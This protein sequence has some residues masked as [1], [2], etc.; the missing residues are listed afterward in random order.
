[1]LRA[2]CLDDYRVRETGRII[3]FAKVVYEIDK[4]SPHYKNQNE[5]LNPKEQVKFAPVKGY[6]GRIE[7]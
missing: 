3:N 5:Y 1:M 4:E 6:H 7:H 2:S